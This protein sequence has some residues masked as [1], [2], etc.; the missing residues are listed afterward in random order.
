MSSNSW[1]CP[2]GKISST[3]SLEM[4]STP[5]RRDIIPNKECAITS[6]LRWVGGGFADEADT[7]EVLRVVSSVLEV[8][9]HHR[10]GGLVPR[11]AQWG[12]AG[13]ILQTRASED[14]VKQNK[15]RRTHL[16]SLCRM[17]WSIMS[18]R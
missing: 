6:L 14:S 3:L 10:N 13:A 15:T 16:A 12:E 5:R 18:M 8:A 17:T 4:T 9:L 11:E 2:K 7:D 1:S